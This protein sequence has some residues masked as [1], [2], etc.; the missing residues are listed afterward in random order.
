MRAFTE[1]MA[2]LHA[3]EAGTRRAPSRDVRS[4]DFTT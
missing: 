2:M 4:L 3:R 1:R